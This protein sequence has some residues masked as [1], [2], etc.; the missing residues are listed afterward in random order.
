MQGFGDYDIAACHFAILA[1]MASK[2]GKLFPALEHYV[3][4]KTQ[5]R[6]QLARELDLKESEIKRVLTATA[7][8][9]RASKNPDAAIP[10]EI[11]KES[12]QVLYRHPVYAAIKQEISKA[13]T[14]IL[15][16]YPPNK[17]GLVNLNGR[18]LTD[19]GS[20]LRRLTA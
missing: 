16:K 18:L 3:N 1:Q 9:A 4:N 7:Y 2:L 6:K 14:F 8:G 11:G 5:I 20:A 15:K 19:F 13:F 17:R 12:A 10:S